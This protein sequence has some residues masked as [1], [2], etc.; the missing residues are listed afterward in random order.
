[1]KAIQ[2]AAQKPHEQLG[3]FSSVMMHA[4]MEKSWKSPNG[5]DLIQM[6]CEY[7]SESAWDWHCVFSTATLLCCCFGLCGC[8]VCR[9]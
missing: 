2:R 3:L 6:H 4:A 1:M 5:S 9:C 8:F 7:H